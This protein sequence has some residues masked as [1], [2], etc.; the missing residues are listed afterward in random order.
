MDIQ[1][2]L[3]SIESWIIE[4]SSG[5]HFINET[6]GV[7]LS[8]KFDGGVQTGVGGVERVIK[9]KQSGISMTATFDVSVEMDRERLKRILE[10]IDL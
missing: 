2:L 9:A 7:D 6:F 8:E 4:G 5:M 1:V 10:L 3:G